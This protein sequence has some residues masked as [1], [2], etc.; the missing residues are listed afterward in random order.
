M[1]DN[2]KEPTMKTTT[3][4]TFIEHCIL[5]AALLALGALCVRHGEDPLGVVKEWAEGWHPANGTCGI[6]TVAGS[7]AMMTGKSSKPSTRSGARLSD[8]SHRR[9]IGKMKSKKPS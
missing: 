8:Y 5:G 7:A 6:E 4:I 3:R 9:S 2:Q 1:N